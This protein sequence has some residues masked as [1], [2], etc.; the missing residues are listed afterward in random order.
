MDN[1]ERNTQLNNNNFTPN[2]NE[3]YI[4]FA[5]LYLEKTVFDSLKKITNN[6][7]LT[8]DSEIIDNYGN[9]INIREEIN[10]FI[11]ILGDDLIKDFDNI[12]NNIDDYFFDYKCKKV[13]EDIIKDLE[14]EINNITEDIENSIDNNIDDKYKLEELKEGL[15]KELKEEVEKV[16]IK[17]IDKI[18]LSNLDKETKKSFIEITKHI[19]NDLKEKLNNF[20]DKFK[21]KENIQ[22]NNNFLDNEIKF[23][24]LNSETVSA[25]IL[26]KLA[27]DNDVSIL[28]KIVSH[29]NTKSSTL[30][31]IYNKTNDFKVLENLLNNDKTPPNIINSLIKNEDRDIFLLSLKHNNISEDMLIKYSKTEDREVLNSILSN[32]KSSEEVLQNIVSY[33]IE[34]EEILKKVINHNGCSEN[35]NNFINEKLNSKNINKKISIKDRIKEKKDIL[36]KNKQQK[37]NIQENKQNKSN[38]RS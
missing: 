35:L 23:E 27:N 4:K 31:D 19:F 6:E 32:D 25:N 22:D 16:E 8:F 20:L 12:T 30:E 26:N 10:E 11:D 18:E 33:N 29:P 1:L 24:L 13:D 15:R 2:N 9:T 28:R 37:S 36:N 38:I 7:N 14:E 17:F 5:K 21:T 3:D 34:N